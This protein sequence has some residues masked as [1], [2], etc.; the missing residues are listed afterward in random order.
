[1]TPRFDAQYRPGMATSLQR[2]YRYVRIAIAAPVVLLLVAVAI[3][4]ASDPSGWHVEPSI[5]DYVHTGAREVFVGSLVAVSLALLAI[6]GRGLE[7]ALLDVAAM[8]API[9]AFVPTPRDGTDPT[10]GVNTSIASYVVVGVILCVVALVVASRS[11]DGSWQP[12]AVGTRISVGIAFAVLVAVALI[13]ALAQ[14]WL[15]D[16][17]HLTAAVLFF[18]C[19]A[20][21]AAL[22]AVPLKWRR[23]QTNGA[24]DP[25]RGQRIV[26]AITAAGIVAVIV[27]LACCVFPRPPE[28][29]GILVL[30]GEFI[31]LV[32]FVIFWLVQSAQKWDEPDPTARFVT[33]RKADV[34]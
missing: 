25:T 18:A 1:M 10:P 32:L 16:H 22:G 33:A 21:V 31:A 17:L 4:S 2:T 11:D 24:N 8:L 6:S 29:R 9:I 34:R 5:S 27:W 15:I 12:P 19:F 23:V 26:Y 3:Q 7:R 14:R 13:N 30:I 20:A 28:D